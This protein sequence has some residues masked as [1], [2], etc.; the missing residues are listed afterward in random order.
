[1]KESEKNRNAGAGKT[2]KELI[3]AS[4]AQLSIVRQEQWRRRVENEQYVEKATFL[5]F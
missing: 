4:I 1:M 5:L 2:L 3:A